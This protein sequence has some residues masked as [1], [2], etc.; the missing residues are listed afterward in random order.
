LQAP[1]D[2]PSAPRKAAGLRYED[3]EFDDKTCDDAAITSITF[4]PKSPPRQHQDSPRKRVLPPRRKREEG[5]FKRVVSDILGGYFPH[6]LEQQAVYYAGT[7]MPAGL[8]EHPKYVKNKGHAAHNRQQRPPRA[9]AAHQQMPQQNGETNMKSGEECHA[10]LLNGCCTKRTPQV[11]L[12]ETLESGG[13]VRMGST[14]STMT[15]WRIELKSDQGSH[16]L[17]SCAAV[18]HT[19]FSCPGT[20]GEGERK[21]RGGGEGGCRGGGREKEIDAVHRQKESEGQGN[22]FI[23]EAL[24]SKIHRCVVTCSAVAGSRACPC[25]GC[26]AK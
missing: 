3:A 19:E 23:I 5:Q 10:K 6:I 20:V 17:S 15:G 2:S 13:R 22:F 4:E 1:Q 18:S 12:S 26:C 16:D 11:D 24:L 8:E 9:Q 25:H 7:S 21:Q 14:A